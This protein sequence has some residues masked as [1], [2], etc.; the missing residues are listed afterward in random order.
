MKKGRGTTALA[1]GHPGGLE[2]VRGVDIGEECLRPDKDSGLVPMP[3]DHG[4]AAPF[5][6][7]CEELAEQKF[8]PHNRSI[9]SPT[10]PLVPACA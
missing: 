3:L 8:L 10:L 1:E 4:F 5:A 2:V 9:A 6:S 7:P